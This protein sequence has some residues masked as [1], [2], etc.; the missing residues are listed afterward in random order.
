[1]A[2]LRLRQHFQPKFISIHVSFAH[3]SQIHSSCK[4]TTLGGSHA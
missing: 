4:L 1:M 3:V 2:V